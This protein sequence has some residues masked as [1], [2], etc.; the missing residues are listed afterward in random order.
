VATALAVS[1]VVAP[2]AV[3]ARG[4]TMSPATLTPTTGA[5]THA[6]ADGVPPA[7]GWEVV[8][9]R[10]HD[11][12]AFTQ[13]LVLDSRGR[14]FESTGLN[15]ASELRE[16]DPVSGA[17]VRSMP[18][19]DEQFGEGLALVDERLVQLTWRNEVAHAW[20]LETFELVESF[21]YAGE[22]WGLCFDGSQLVMSDGSDRLT[23][24]DPDTF[25]AVG[26]ISV[27]LAGEPRDRLNELECVDGSVWANVLGSD[28]IVRIDPGSGKVDARLDMTGV[29]EPNPRLNDSRAVLNGIAYDA[30]ADTFLLTGKHWPEL[31]E[32][33]IHG[34]D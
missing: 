8:S 33:R 28:V 6:A 30:G 34:G 31:V 5:P 22:G 32:I 10:P 20:D 2:A 15:G 27:T 18:L 7:L 26:S 11:D 17:V 24:R 19:P 9:R 14:L 4:P 3:Q 23:F 25:D 16:V 21:S 29:L 1:L 13:G 12:S